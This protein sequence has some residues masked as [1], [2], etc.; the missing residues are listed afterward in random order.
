M[1]DLGKIFQ[2]ILKI[3]LIELKFVLYNALTELP[4]VALLIICWH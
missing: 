1:I 2:N 3:F 4:K